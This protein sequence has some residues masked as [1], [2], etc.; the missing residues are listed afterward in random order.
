MVPRMAHTCFPQEKKKEKKKGNNST[1][2][3]I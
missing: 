1:G 2:A 3:S